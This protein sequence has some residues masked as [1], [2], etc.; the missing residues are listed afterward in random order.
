MKVTLLASTAIE[1]DATYHG[2]REEDGLHM[3]DMDDRTKQWMESDPDAGDIENLIEFAG[4][5]C[6]QSFHKPNPATA[7]NQDYIA[8]ILNQGHFSVLEHA[9][10]TFYVEGVSR[11][12]THELIRHRHLSYSELSQRFVD[13]GTVGTV[14]PPAIRDLD[15]ETSG[16]RDMNDTVDKARI[17]YGVIVRKLTEAGLP[18]K[19]ARE[20]ARAV[21]PNA[22]ETR[23]VVTGNMRAWRDMLMKRYSKHADAEIREFAAEVLRQLRELAPAVFQDFPEKPFE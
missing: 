11:A 6:Y 18:R 20:A 12:L 22:T 1:I 21:M 3:M 5:S 4:R 15:I 16:R 19:Q 14:V 17:N 9:S 10:A 13:V 23:I 8:N 2:P 7:R